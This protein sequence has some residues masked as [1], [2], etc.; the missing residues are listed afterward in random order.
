MKFDFFKVS[1]QLYIWPTVKVTYD[2]WLNG[3]YELIFIWL[4]VG[5]SIGYEK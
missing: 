2:P 1:C 4:N 5:L 3:S